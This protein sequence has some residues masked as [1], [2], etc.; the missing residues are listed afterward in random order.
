M[1]FNDRRNRREKRPKSASEL[2][3][4][5]DALEFRL[6]TEALKF[7]EEKKMRGTIRELKKQ[8]KSY[9]ERLKVAVA[10][11]SSPV[12]KGGVIVAK[13]APVEEL[14][15]N[16][17]TLIKNARLAKKQTHAEFAAFL[18]RKESEVAKWELG[19]LKPSIDTAKKLERKLKITLVVEGGV[20]TADAGDI[21]KSLTPVKGTKAAT[22]GDLVKVKVR[23][24]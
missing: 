11:K 20:D 22:L 16:Y 21:L 7:S 18:Q 23:N 9:V 2:Q 6:E 5:I 17:S 10:S 12:R 3:K 4:D 24:R 13:S 15:S 19:S 8:K 14:V 1:G